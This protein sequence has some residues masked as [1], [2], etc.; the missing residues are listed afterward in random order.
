MERQCRKSALIRYIKL[1]SN[2][3]RA[4]QGTAVR[5]EP[6]T[7]FGVRVMPQIRIRNRKVGRAML[8]HAALGIGLAG[9]VLGANSAA[10]AG[11]DD[12][13]SSVMGK[14]METFGLRDPKGSYAGIDYNERSP[15]V[16]PPT[17]D[18]PP[19]EA[20]TAPPVPNWPKDQDMIRRAKAKAE[21]KKVA[22]HPDY[23]AD[24]SRP[25]R[26]NELDPAGA[27]RVNTPI[28]SSASANSQMSDPRDTGA[29]KSL[30]S[31]IFASK[32]EYTTFTGEPSRQT[33]TDPPPGYLTPSPDQPYGVGQAPSN[34]KV[35]SLGERVEPTR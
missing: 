35:K 24:S 4:V 12:D 16:V 19:P 1:V 10:R 30:F 7:V 17:R 18:L 2:G 5:G 31:S 29:K 9:L 6:F 32:N 22:P 13:S 26:P 27:P 14:V 3:I 34:Y 25:L 28:D 15:L 33:L 23:V 8:V 21:E 11:D 20:S